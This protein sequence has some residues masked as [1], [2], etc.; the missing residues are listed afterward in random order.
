MS[1]L[2]SLPTAS[3]DL[4]S[5]DPTADGGQPSLM[6]SSFS[7]ASQEQNEWCWSAVALAITSFYGI[8][9]GTT[10]CQL[11][12]SVLNLATCCDTPGGCNSTAELQ[13]ALAKAGVATYVYA[14]PLGAPDITNQLQHQRPIGVR[15][16]WGTT[17]SAHFISVFG[18]YDTGDQGI[19]VDVGD[20]DPAVGLG[21]TSLAAL[22]SNYRSAGGF[23]SHYYLT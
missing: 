9:T 4:T 15:I 8:G 2:D 7:I 1:A 11:A 13:T 22:T 18:I 19:W 21:S 10:Q 17:N 3:L 20:P 23:L 12:S 16:V 5:P 14:A 6:L